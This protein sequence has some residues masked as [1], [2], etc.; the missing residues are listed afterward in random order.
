MR[1]QDKKKNMEK[2]NKLFQERTNSESAYAEEKEIK[3]TFIPDLY[4]KLSKLI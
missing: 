1:R 4:P 2:V 3:Y